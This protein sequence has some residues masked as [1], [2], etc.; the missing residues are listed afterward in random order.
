[1]DLDKDLREMPAQGRISLYMS[2]ENTERNQAIY[3]AF[4]DYARVEWENDYTNAL[5]YLLL[6]YE[7]DARLVSIENSI[8]TL[9]NEL[10]E[11]RKL[12]SESKGESKT[13]AEDNDGDTF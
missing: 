5:G 2:S 12:L 4:R 6:F 3:D 10:D 11:L 9:K 13:E 8:L 1:M 7:E